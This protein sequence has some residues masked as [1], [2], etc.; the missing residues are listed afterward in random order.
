VAYQSLSYLKIL[1][2]PYVL[3]F[4]GSKSVFDGVEFYLPQLAHMIIHLEVEWDDEILERFALVIAQQSVHFSLQLNW[5]LQGALEDYHPESIAEPGKPNKNYNPMFYSRCLK[6]LKNVERCVVYGK[7]RAAEL[8]RLYEGGQITKAELLLMEQADRRFNALQITAADDN[9][10]IRFD[11]VDGYLYLQINNNGGAKNGLIQSDASNNNGNNMGL[12]AKYQFCSLDK[13]VLECFKSK[14]C[15]CSSEL[16]L[17]RAF[18]L[19]KANVIELEKLGVR[20]ITEKGSDF[21]LRCSTPEEHKL[22]VRRLKEEA[23]V[24]LLFSSATKGT[25]LI[26]T[27]GGVTTS[28]LKKD[29]SPSQLSRFE[30]FQNERDFVDQLTRI[31]EDL[32][33]L[34]RSDRKKQAPPMMAKLVI[35]PNVYLPLCNS[36]DTWRRVADKLADETRVFNT[37]ERCPTV[38]H[39][40]TRRGEGRFEQ[41]VDVAEYMHNNFDVT[42][43]IDVVPEEGEVD[44]FVNRKTDSIKN[45]NHGSSVAGGRSNVWHDDD[46]DPEGSKTD[47]QASASKLVDKKKGNQKVQRL[48]RDSV[49][50]IPNMLSK[51][52]NT[53]KSAKKAVSL[54]DRQTELGPVVPIIEGESKAL[55]FDDAS[56]MSMEP[57]S[58]VLFKDKIVMGYIDEGEIDHEAIQ[59]STEYVCNGETWAAKS[60]SML[61][62]AR[63][64]CDDKGASCQL[65]IVSCL[66]K[67]NDDLRQE[68]FVMQMI[69]FYKSVFAKAQLPIYLKTYRILST[70]SQ[71]GL[72]ELLTDAVSLDGLKKSEGYPVEG[73][74]RAYFEKV[75]GK[76]DSKA[77]KAARTNFIQSL[78]GYSIVSYLLGLKDRHNGNIMIDTRGHLIQID[79][80]FAMGM[81]P[82]NDFSME[83]APFKFTKEYLEV[84]GGLGSAGHVE[85]ERLFVAGMKEARK[86]SQIALGLVEIMMYK[87]NYPCFCGKFG[88]GRALTGFE[89]RLMLK[90]PDNKVEAKAIALVNKA[91]QH[92]GTYLYDAFQLKSNGY[93]M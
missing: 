37:K 82:G 38:M 14:G 4:S 40:V 86:N 24:S 58:S 8:L 17:D 22:W 32:R 7:P 61:E 27:D 68:V 28:M 57:R 59:R 33:F 9:V 88:N 72:L 70:S 62:K 6:L 52:L 18:A 1:S 10:V 34:E 79:F 25:D 55:E 41:N 51:R 15:G 16:E 91:R 64:Q 2:A 36:S 31:A 44:E 74:L 65:E 56:V 85:F 75:Y 26:K 93:A 54:M 78:V 42:A 46:E 11:K 49:V 63:K 47:L 39:F 43:E 30:F 12:L 20:V 77:F 89:E 3:Q 76:P 83:R 66:S 87:S 13:H 67:S 23:Q 48:L 81:A 19:E 60:A 71:T 69:H 92:L 80:G 84:M 90:V 50:T 5:I 53:A 45:S 73:G 29:L 35:P 21:T